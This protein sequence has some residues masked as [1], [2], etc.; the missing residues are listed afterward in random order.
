M[1][2]K[3][4][5]AILLGLGVVLLVLSAFAGPIGIGA[6]DAIGWKQITGIVVSAAV[7]VIGA[8][9]MRAKSGETTSAAIDA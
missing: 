5:G 7:I 2:R 9:L 6:D 3:R 8:L 4:F 1:E